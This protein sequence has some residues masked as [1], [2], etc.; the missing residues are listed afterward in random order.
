MGGRGINARF[1]WDQMKPQIHPFSPDNPLLIWTGPLA[2]T[3]APAS[4]RLTVSAKSPETHFY[5]KSTSG[6]HVA[7]E[8]KFA[9]YDGMVITGATEDPVYLSI[10]DQEIQIK[11]AKHLWGKDVRETDCLIKQELNDDRVNILSIG[12]AGEKKVSYAAVM[13]N[14]YRCASRGGMGAVMGSKGLK[15]IAVRGTQPVKVADPD[16]FWKDA[17]R[18]RQLVKWDRDRFFRY[19]LFGTQRGLVWANEIGFNP[20]RNYQTGSMKDAY[21]AGGEYI[22]ERYQTGETGCGSCVLNCGTFYDTEEGPYGRIYSEGPEWETVNSFGARLGIP[23]PLFV[24]KAN[25]FCNIQGLDISSAGA[26]LGFVMELFEKGLV[27]KEDLDGITLDWGNGPGCLR[28]LDKIVRRE[29]IG[30]LLAESIKTISERIGRESENYALH[31]KGLGMTSVD[32]RLTKAYALAFAVNPRGG[33]HLHSEVICQYGSTPEHVEIAKRISGS[34][35]GAEPLST[36][37]K[38]RMVKYH[39]EV[40]CASDSVGFCFFHTLSSHRVTPERIALLF[41]Q[42]T[43]IP[44]SADDLHQSAE[45]IINLERAFNIREGLTRKDDTLPPRMLNEPIPDGPS[46][47]AR[48]TKE[49]LEGMLAEYYQ[50]HGWNSQTGVPLEETLHRLGLQDVAEEL[51]RLR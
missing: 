14:I 33:D 16:G 42:A 51:K 4:S 19:Y 32:S 48:I 17:L 11:D 49:E 18:A 41:Q 22:R 36:E 21:K 29:G 50:I 30:D 12:P 1:L 37:G 45:R 47:G 15:A 20:A 31:V 13:A 3:I 44:F 24:L 10:R 8:L 34:P 5:C 7:P 38:A 6:G 27:S 2:G 9:G 35:R 39:E 23:D 25:E 46:Q 28:I 40:C 26:N 43:G